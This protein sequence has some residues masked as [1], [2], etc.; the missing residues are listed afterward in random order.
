MEKKPWL[1]SDIIELFSSHETEPVYDL[2]KGIGDDCAVIRPSDRQDLVV[3]ADMLVED[4]H[5]NRSWH[6]PFAL[7]RKAMAVNISDIAAM[8]GTPRFAFLCI[9]LPGQLDQDWLV[10]FR[11]GFRSILSEYAITLAGGD[12]VRGAKLNISITLL[13]S[14]PASRAVFRKGAGPGDSIYVSG[15]LG[16][17]AAG[18]ALCQ[19]PHVCSALDERMVHPFLQRHLDPTP[20]LACGILLAQSGYVTAMQDI[21]DGIAT[22]LAHLCRHSDVGAE[23]DS[24]RI[25]GHEHLPGICAALNRNPMHMMVS[26]GEDYHLVFTVKAGEEQALEQYLAGKTNQAVYRIGTITS[27]SGVTLCTGKGK[28]DITFKGYKHSGSN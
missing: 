28:K 24:L 27:G 17:A 2:I 18:L 12:T 1:E 10:A 13:G 7:G 14:V 8:G 26:G 16:S 5:F 9:A 25:P 20:D 22:D 23:I 19:S 4:V 15:H 11:D 3:T 6:P 21:S